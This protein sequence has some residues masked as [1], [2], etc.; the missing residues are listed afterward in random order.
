MP[1]LFLTADVVGRAKLVRPTAGSAL[2]ER[3]IVRTHA[4]AMNGQ[5]REGRVHFAEILTLMP[6][7]PGAGGP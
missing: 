3:H 6:T 4:C 7:K 2:D 5:R 1:S